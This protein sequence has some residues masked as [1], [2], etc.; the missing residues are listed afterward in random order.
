MS[1][2]FDY[3]FYHEV[4]NTTENTNQNESNSVSEIDLGLDVLLD[5]SFN[6]KSEVTI[7]KNE[8]E[9]SRYIDSLK[10]KSLKERINNHL[11]PTDNYKKFSTDNSI[12]TGSLTL[13]EFQSSKSITGAT[14]YLNEV[15][16]LSVID[17]DINHHENDLMDETEA[18][19]TRKYI[20]NVCKTN[21]YVLAQT[22][23]GGFHIY[24]NNDDEFFNRFDPKSEKNSFAQISIEKGLDLDL[25]TS[26][27]PNNRQNCLVIGSK[28]IYDKDPTKTIKQS[29]FINGSYDWPVPYSIKDVLKTF[30]WIEAVEDKYNKPKTSKPV[31]SEEYNYD[32]PSEEVLLTLIN[33]LN[34]FKIHNCAHSGKKLEDEVALIHFFQ[35]VNCLDEKLKEKAIR[36]V[37]QNNLLTL[38]AN[39]HFDEVCDSVGDEKSHIGCLFNIIKFHNPDYYKQ[40]IL[41]LIGGVH[42]KKFDILN[43][44]FTVIEFTKKAR[45]HKY[46][47]LEAAAN[48]LLRFIR[49]HSFEDKMYIEKGYKI[50]E[51]EDDEFDE[52]YDPENEKK[53]ISFSYQT[54][55][56]IKNELSRIDLHIPKGKNSS[57]SAWDAFVKY[58]EYFHFHFI[59]FNDKRSEKNYQIISYFHG[60]NY[61][62]L[63]EINQDLI[64]DFLM[65]IK[66]GISNNDPVVYDYI[67]KWIAN[68]IQNP[69]TKNEVGLVLLG[70][71]GTGKTVFTDTL[72]ELF[73]GYSETITDIAELTGNYTS[74]VENNILLVANE[75]SSAKDEFIKDMNSLKA[76][77]TDRTKRGREIYGKFHNMK[78]VANLI[79]CSNFTR[80]IIIDDTDRRY[81]VM[82]VSNK[83][84]RNFKFFS[85]LCKNRTSTFYDNLITYF[86]NIDLSDFNPRNFPITEE[87]KR[88]IGLCR[89][90]EEKFIIENYKGFVNGMTLDEVK[91]CYRDYFGSFTVAEFNKFKDKIK[92]K[93]ENEGRKKASRINSEGKRPYLFV[94]KEEYVETFKPIDSSEEEDSEF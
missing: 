50:N 93:F 80:P 27:N 42:V 16:Y 77:I 61:Q 81:C 66:E 9:K 28:I 74:V 14:I 32:N 87:R 20:K 65:L 13:D 58:S 91:F 70:E 31:N 39:D 41:P 49:F 44:P 6:E 71:P 60:F 86:S 83:F 34:G 21:D 55:K 5:I 69:G 45:A 25:F 67:I 33:G 7:D 22:P 19:R 57:Y 46:K 43:D 75:L 68:M 82:D 37:F 64:K 4:N 63:Q 56:A 47:T 2:S 84:K 30:N 18:E 72:C 38:N 94:L 62:K 76:I 53:F 59:T 54:D 85:K 12:K 89:P 26:R 17:I 23:S 3:D 8:I 36:K 29:K 1:E 52:N 10:S 79:F 78:N 24:C 48:D 92:S 15:E 73:S 90:I 51:N 88:L 40:S 35:A 11:V